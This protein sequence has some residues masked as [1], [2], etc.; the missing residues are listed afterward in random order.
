MAYNK[1]DY[2]NY[3]YLTQESGDSI[4]ANDNEYLKSIYSKKQLID[5]FK[6]H[7]QE[8]EDFSEKFKDFIQTSNNINYRMI[9]VSYYETSCDLY[10]DSYVYDDYDYRYVYNGTYYH[11][12]LR[13]FK[14][15]PL[16]NIFKGL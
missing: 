15:S 5:F 1:N 16:L 13:E 2:K 9:Y 11:S 3:Y 14:Y 7:V 12:T 10:W 6:K 8:N 4:R